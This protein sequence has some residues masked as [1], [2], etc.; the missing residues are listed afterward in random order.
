[1]FSYE[2]LLSKYN[3][4]LKENKEL[5]SQVTELKT[6]LGMPIET[7]EVVVET[8]DAVINK[9]SSTT[10]KILLYR[11]LF[12]GRE[13]VFARRWYSKTTEK[14]GY[15][16]V[17]E[18]EW[19]DGLCDKRKYKCSVCPNRKLSP[20]TDEDIYKHLEGKDY[21]GKDVIGIYPILVDET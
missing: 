2:E 21:Y 4:L 1:M 11:S 10:E 8:S 12:C 17:C 3:I 15:Q 19:A 14:S 20:I 16:P 6:K 9:Y 18:N 13:D 7:E 5:K